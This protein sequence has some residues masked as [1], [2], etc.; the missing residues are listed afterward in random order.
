LI[1]IEI[2]PSVR[3][4]GKGAFDGC[5][6]R[7]P[8]TGLGDVAAVPITFPEV[9]DDPVATSKASRPYQE[10][11]PM[12]KEL[13]SLLE[14]VD[15]KL[16]EESKRTI[17]KLITDCK[18]TI[19]ATGKGKVTAPTVGSVSSAMSSSN[20]KRKTHGTEDNK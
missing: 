4:V 18:S 15:G 9:A 16:L 1:S 11:V 14:G 10:M 3:T 8:Q 6:C 19:V 7:P 17:Q 20:K 12:C 2:P 13:C 5:P